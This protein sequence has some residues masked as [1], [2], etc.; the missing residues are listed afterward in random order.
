MHDKV[1]KAKIVS[2]SS[3][4][5]PHGQPGGSES[6][7]LFCFP[8][9]G[10]AAAGYRDWSAK[11]PAGVEVMAVQF[12]GRG[13][14]LFEEP[15]RQMDVLVRATVAAM[16]PFL[17]RP[18]AFFGHSMGALI[19]FE[20]ARL[21]RARYGIAP[22]KLFVGACRDPKGMEVQQTRRHELPLPELIEEL[23]RLNGTPR[24]IL[25]DPAALGCF[26]P[27][28][29]ADF[30][31]VDT[32]TYRPEPPLG[33][34]IQAFGGLQ[35]AISVEELA[36]WADHTVAGFSMEMLDGD[37]FFILHHTDA[38]LRLMSRELSAIVEL[39]ST[40]GAAGLSR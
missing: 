36:R 22:E 13:A 35:D 30:E 29:R 23:E 12:P 15:I 3:R 40:Q 8:F 33:C 14:R 7:R 32:Y 2:P 21:L 24:E 39:Q 31:V 28:I 26:L 18:F 25:N 37:H 6:L 19:G 34:P 11:V 27:A 17:D 16:L 20:A 4:W 9:A 10:G 38:L 1:R 5:F